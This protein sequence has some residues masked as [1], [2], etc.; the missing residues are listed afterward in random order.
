MVERGKDHIVAYLTTVTDID[1]SV[2]LKMAAGV[3]EH[4]FTQMDV[5][6]VVGIE[7]RKYP[8]C[9]GHIVAKYRG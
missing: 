7:R 1:A 3:D 9:G 2:V 5:S 4:I 6:A 8:K